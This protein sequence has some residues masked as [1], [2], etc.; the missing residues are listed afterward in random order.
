M[1]T[2]PAFADAIRAVGGGRHAARALST[3][4]GMVLAAIAHLQPVPRAE[5]SRTLGSE[6]SRDLL[7]RLRAIGLIA[8]GPRSPSPGAP[9]AMVT[10]KGFLEQFGL[11]SLADLPEVEGVDRPAD[12]TL[13]GKI[14]G[15]DRSWMEKEEGDDE[16][17]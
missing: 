10:T 1:R 7:A 4:E 15:V 14:P 5:L 12:D 8:S 11:D 2:R 16:A 13:D 9:P 3:Q 6:V 17:L